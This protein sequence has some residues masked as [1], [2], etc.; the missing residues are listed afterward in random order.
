MKQLLGK[1]IIIIMVL[2]IL[3]NYCCLLLIR[4]FTKRIYVPLPDF[5][6]SCK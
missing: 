5:A 3:L 2:V 6:V 1:L 4:R